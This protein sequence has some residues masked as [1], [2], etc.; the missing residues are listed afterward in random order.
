MQLGFNRVN[1]IQDIINNKFNGNITKCATELSLSNSYLHAVIYDTKNK[2]GM[3]LLNAIIYY[4]MK[5]KIDYRKYIFI[6][7]RN[8]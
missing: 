7:R 6:N 5:N 8:K 3:K 1:F 4:C 2:G